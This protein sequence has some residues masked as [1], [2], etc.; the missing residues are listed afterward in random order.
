MTT[1]L[2]LVLISSTVFSSMSIAEETVK[3]CSIELK[4]PGND[5]VI[6][7]T[8]KIVKNGEKLIAKTTQTENNSVTELPEES[9]SIAEYSVRADLKST[10]P[11]MNQAESLIQGTMDYLKIPNFGSLFSVGLDLNSIRNAKV[12]QIGKFTNMGGTVIIEAKD[13]NGKAIG[14]FVTGFMP[15][16]CK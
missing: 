4:I 11:D 8:F 15:F 7:T 9:A 12:Y 5:R 6:P 14:S 2:S 1:V 13:K 3:T 16:A 10:T